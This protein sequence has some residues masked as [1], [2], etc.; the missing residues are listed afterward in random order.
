[1][2]LKMD[3]TLP[4]FHVLAK[5][6]GAICNLACEYCFYLEKEHVVPHAKKFRMAPDV[7][8]SFIRQKIEADPDD[9]RRIVTVWGKGYRFEP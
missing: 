3:S 1:M 7:L 4:A 9:P 5:P 2:K 6:T 8:E